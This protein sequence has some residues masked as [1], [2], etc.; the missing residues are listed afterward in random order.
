MSAS[1]SSLELQGISRNPF[2]T[3]SEIVKSPSS[4]SIQFDGE[5]SFHKSG[6]N[7]TYR[8][9]EPNVEP[10]LRP[11][12]RPRRRMG[13]WHSITNHC[14]ACCIVCGAIVALVTIPLS[15]LG[16]NSLYVSPDFPS[17]GVCE[18]DGN[19][20]TGLDPVSIWMPSK[21]FQITLG[22]GS[23]S[24]ST[25]KFID[26]VW[27]IVGGLTDSLDAMLT[28]PRSSGADYRAF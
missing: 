18:P 24:F 3:D 13:K 16:A 19:F 26:I 20:D 9:V 10:P 7:S 4:R 22:F 5:D 6:T 25:A 2:E 27:D 17:F 1:Y 15:N 12:L 14:N 28:A 23:F 21:A 11:N 8:P